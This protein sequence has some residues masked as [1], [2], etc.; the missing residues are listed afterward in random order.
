MT[1]F[2]AVAPPPCISLTSVLHI[3]RSLETIYEEDQEGED[4]EVDGLITGT[5]SSSS[6]SSLAA[7]FAPV[8]SNC[9]LGLAQ[10]SYYVHPVRLA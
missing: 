10:R 2:S 1:P 5:W 7:P 6:Q 9:S 3:R 4:E 8:K